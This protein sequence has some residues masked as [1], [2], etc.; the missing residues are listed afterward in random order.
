M[1]LLDRYLLR[2]F[3]RHFLLVAAGFIAIYLLVDFFEKIDN[4]TSAGKSIW[5]AMQFFLLNIPFI[6]DQLGPILI[7]LSGVITLGILNQTNELNALKAGA[8]PLAK[9]VRPILMGGLL[10]TG[11]FFV[12]AQWVLP[13]TMP[14]ASSIWDQQVRGKLPLGIYRNGRYYYKGEEG[15]YSFRR[16]NVADL[17]F[18]DFSYSCWDQNYNTKSLLTAARAHWDATS[19]A[20]VFQSIQLQE[21]QNDGSYLVHNAASRQMQLPESPLD[22]VVPENESI[23]QSLT[24]LFQAIDKSKT[25]WQSNKAWT[26]FLSRISYLLLGMPLLLLGLPSLLFCYKK[27][28]RDLYIAIPASCGI[29]FLSWGIWGTLQSLAGA[30][31]LPPLLAA[32]CLHLL[33]ALTGIILLKREDS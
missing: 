24:G 21:R 10:L 2:Q 18:D 3:T 16:E 29:A 33:L 32:T 26:D 11:L 15:F 1:K 25:A 31:Y 20:W 19:K 8:I 4:F 5:L 6:L 9:I 23:E 7:F 27:W 22:F 17:A 13:F 28:G 30:G 14:A 12:A